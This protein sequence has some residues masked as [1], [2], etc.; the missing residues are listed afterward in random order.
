MKSKG[1]TKDALSLM[2]QQGM[3]GSEEHILGNIF[4]KLSD[5]GTELKTIEP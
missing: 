2:F 1:E 3:D 5:T 4:L